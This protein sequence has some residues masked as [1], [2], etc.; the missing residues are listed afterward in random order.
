MVGVWTYVEGGGEG[1]GFAAGGEWGV[2][3]K[4]DSK[5]FE[6]STWKGGVGMTMKVVKGM[7][8]GGLLG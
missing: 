7:V 5:V 8:E 2:R 4:R 6:L 1:P 3:G